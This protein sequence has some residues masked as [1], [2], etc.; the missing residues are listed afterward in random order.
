VLEMC[1]KKL[2]NFF[3]ARPR[4]SQVINMISSNVKVLRFAQSW[5]KPKQVADIFPYLI[6]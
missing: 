2:L 4:S 3:V 1:K 6:H 5:A